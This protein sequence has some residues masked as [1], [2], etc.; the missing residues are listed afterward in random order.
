MKF[1]ITMA[2]IKSTDFIFMLHMDQCAFSSLNP[3]REEFTL[4]LFDENSVGIFRLFVDCV[5]CVLR[6]NKNL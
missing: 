6:Y 1:P 4:D 3:K 5:C 2:N